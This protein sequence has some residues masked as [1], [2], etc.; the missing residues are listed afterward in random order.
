MSYKGEQLNRN[1]VLQGKLDVTGGGEN[2]HVHWK[3][4]GDSNRILLCHISFQP[5]GRCNR[6][7]P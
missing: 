4:D 7:D 1:Y 6:G 2:A 3:F 5:I